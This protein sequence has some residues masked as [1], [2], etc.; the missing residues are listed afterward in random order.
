M[1]NERKRT[2]S[3]DYILSLIGVIFLMGVTLPT[4][5]ADVARFSNLGFSQ[6]S[7]VFVF[8]QHGIAR[9]TGLPYGEIY[10]VDVPGNAFIREGVRQHT[11]TTPISPG[12]DGIGAVLNLL[13]PI[14]P[15]MERLGIDHLRQGRIV[16][17][18]F[19][20]TDPPQN[21]SFRDFRDNTQYTIS[22]TQ[23][24]RGSGRE[25]S[26]AFHLD[27]NVRTADGSSQHHRVGR[28]GFFRDGVNEY[29]LGQVIVGPDNRSLIMVM[30]R[31][32]HVPAG[33]QIRYMVETVRLR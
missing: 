11:Y 14:A 33:R 9:D 13:R 22:I 20:Q 1:V 27:M 23:E 21:I 17:L 16:Y 12:Q 19:N 26:A 10:T 6:D 8:S 4:A 5:A 30:E 28:Q 3:R 25:G 15:V 32:T 31:I 2:N 29:A 7:R 24:S 18:A